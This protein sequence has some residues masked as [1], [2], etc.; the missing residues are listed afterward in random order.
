LRTVNLFLSGRLQTKSDEQR[1]RETRKRW[2]EFL[3]EDLPRIEEAIA[4]ETWIW[5]PTETDPV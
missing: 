1:K 3:D 4:S 2:D 5:E